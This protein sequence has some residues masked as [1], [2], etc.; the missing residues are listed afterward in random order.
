MSPKKTCLVIK[1][2]VKTSASGCSRL[3]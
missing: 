2:D 1:Y 3:C